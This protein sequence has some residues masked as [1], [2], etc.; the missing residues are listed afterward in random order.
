MI[1]LVA[2]DAD[3]TD[4]SL[5]LDLAGSATYVVELFSMLLGPFLSTRLD[6]PELFVNKFVSLQYA[7]CD[8]PGCLN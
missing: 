8:V 3:A 2:L 6:D 5:L 4:A 7:V 1:G